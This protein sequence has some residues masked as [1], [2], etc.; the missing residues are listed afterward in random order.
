[1]NTF[2]LL[3][4]LI[5]FISI[6]GFVLNKAETY[7]IL[8]KT[9]SIISEKIRLIIRK[10]DTGF[11]SLFIVLLKLNKSTVIKIDAIIGIPGINQVRFNNIVL[12]QASFHI[13]PYI[14]LLILEGQKQSPKQG[15][16]E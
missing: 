15:K 4:L 16:L 11:V 5:L 8:K 2:I 10:Y 14:L 1:M 13:K 7:S 6:F 3:F 9:K 12:N